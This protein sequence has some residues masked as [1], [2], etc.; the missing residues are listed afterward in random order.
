MMTMNMLKWCWQDKR[1]MNL[2]PVPIEVPA[3]LHEKWEWN[4]KQLLFK[5]AVLS[6]KKETFKKWHIGTKH[7]RSPWCWNMVSSLKVRHQNLFTRF[8][9]TLN[10]VHFSSPRIV[11]FTFFSGLDAWIATLCFSHC[12]FLKSKQ[13]KIF[14]LLHGNFVDLDLDFVCLQRRGAETHL[15]SIYKGR[16]GL[17]LALA[18]VNEQHWMD[19][20]GWGTKEDINSVLAPFSA[21]PVNHT[22][23]YQTIS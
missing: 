5:C 16:Y 12:F 1:Y 18:C 2:N 4:C 6:V 15:E 9:T 8:C 17:E 11:R 7:A 21:I 19:L 13:S 20:V 14:L 23:L 22:R 3:S 10:G